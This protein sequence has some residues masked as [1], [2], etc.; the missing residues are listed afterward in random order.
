LALFGSTPLAKSAGAILP[1]SRAVLLMSHQLAGGDVGLAAVECAK[2]ERSLVARGEHVVTEETAPLASVVR[3]GLRRRLS[4]FVG[5]LATPTE[6]WYKVLMIEGLRLLYLLTIPQ[7]YA[8]GLTNWM[9]REPCQQMLAA[10]P[11]TKNG[12][13]AR[14]VVKLPPQPGVPMSSR[15]H[16]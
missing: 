9:T 8:D 5:H 10:A 6:N 4:G 15:D 13:L 2:M 7:G 16:R 1:S 3:G 11:A 12:L 14:C